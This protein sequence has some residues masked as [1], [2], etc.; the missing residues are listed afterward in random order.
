MGQL[1]DGNFYAAAPVEGEAGW[2]LVFA[3][4]YQ[5]KCLQDDGVT[6]KSLDV[7]E[8]AG[9][10]SAIET[11][12]KPEWAFVLVAT[13]TTLRS[14]I[15]P[16]RMVNAL[17]QPSLRKDLKWVCSWFLQA[18]RLLQDSTVKRKGRA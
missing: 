13:S 3:E 12:K 16:S 6:E 14:M 17:L 15:Q 10:K 9:L 5:E 8:G 1:E 18:L 4:D 11:G 2:G 7:W